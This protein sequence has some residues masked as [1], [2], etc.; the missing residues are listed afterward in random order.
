MTAA[1]FAKL[2]KGARRRADGTWWDSQ[3]PA[4]D[5]RKASLS[6][7]D[8]D[9]GLIVTCQA[10]RCTVDA[11][12]TAVG[13]RVADFFSAKGAGF[14]TGPSVV[15]TYNYTDAGGELLY[16]VE[17]REPKD[18]RCRRPDSLGGW[19]W[20]LDSVDVVPYRLHELAEARRVYIAEGEKDCD[21]LAALGLT[22]TTNH[23]GAG[24]WREEHTR[25]LVAAA[26]PEVV[27]LRDNDRPGAAHQDAVARSCAAAKLRVKRL[28]L[29]GLPPLREKHGEDVS[30]WLTLGHASAELEALADA[31]PI[32]EPAAATE[33][34]TA[35]VGDGA[36]EP[37]LRREGL[38]LALV[39][40]DGVRFSLTAIRDGR[41]GV[42]GEL[43]VTRAGRRLS[44]TAFSQPSAQ[45][46]E[47]LRK[48]LEAI[49]P[50]VPWSGYL[51][52][53]AWR[54]T[55]AARQGEPIVTLT[56]TV[57][58]PTRE[59]V[60]RFLVRRGADPRLRGRRHRKVTRRARDC[61]RGPERRRPALWPQAG[62]DRAGC[63]S[64][65]GDEPRY[66]RVALGAHRSR[67]RDRPA[68]DHIQTHDPA[69]R[70]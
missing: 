64:R 19:T 39:W 56:G 2:V 20:N 13:K 7:R 68:R 55:Q 29:P 4:H 21:T 15:A 47:T 6:F 61:C 24:K 28:V 54:F 45:A 17:R 52:E 46:R 42:R 51:E 34:A 59:L 30:D 31:A 49:A 18:F 60:P 32:F 22:A 25:A 3:C 65:L 38:D 11:I 50:D 63:V 14:D 5:D 70:R 40:P 35:P 36:A 66:A 57:T 33:P 10:H 16:V 53:A 23:G 27:V 43:T 58:S 48:K 44:W 12:A 41:D 9:R 26:V 8:G 69:A 62:A 1:E 37:E 67:T